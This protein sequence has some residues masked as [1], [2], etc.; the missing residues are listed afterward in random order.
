M[1]DDDH[2]AVLPGVD[3]LKRFRKAREAPEIDACLGLVEDHELRL[4]REDRGDLDAL[5]LAA[6][7][8]GVH[9]AVK[10]IGRA[11][12]DLREILAGL[13]P[14]QELLSRRDRQKILHAD[15][16]EARRLLEAVADAAARALGDGKAGHI[17]AVPE[18]AAACRHHK[19]HDRLGKRRFAAA[20]RPGENDELFVRDGEGNVPQYLGAA[21]RRVHGIVYILQ[22]QH[23][24]V[25]FSAVCLENLHL[26]K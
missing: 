6:G 15:A 25:S 10:I 11:Q 8:G 4:P 7:E 16:L 12:A 18:D 19:A 22:L 13:A 1:G 14:R 5:D 2:R 21:L 17:L 9:L 20:V 23:G 26:S 24:C 3:L